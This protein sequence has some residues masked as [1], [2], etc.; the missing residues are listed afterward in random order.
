MFD[1]MCNTQKLLL[2]NQHNGDDALQN[3][4]KKTYTADK[5][6]TSV[7]ETFQENSFILK[8]ARSSE[9]F[10]YINSITRCQRKKTV[11]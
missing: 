5:Y 9:T 6:V 11:T 8:M 1:C 7:S 2:L 10:I 4:K 3:L